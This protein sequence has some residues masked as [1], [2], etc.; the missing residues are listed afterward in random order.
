MQNIFAVPEVQAAD[1]KGKLHEH[2]QELKPKK[3]T[4]VEAVE[5]LDEG[6]TIPILAC[7][8]FVSFFTS[9]FYK[10]SFRIFYTWRKYIQRNLQH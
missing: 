8:L 3:E 1:P 5:K 10:I 6:S 4:E 9:I 2:K 7:T